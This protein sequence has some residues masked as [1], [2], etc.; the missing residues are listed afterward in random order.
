[1]S[2][3]CAVGATPHVAQFATT[4]HR[5]SAVDGRTTRHSGYAVSQQ[6]RKLVEQGFGWM[7]A[8][9]GLRKLRHRGGPLVTWIYLH[10]GRLQHRAT[11]AT[12][13]GDGMTAARQQSSTSAH[14]NPAGTDVPEA[15][16][17]EPEAAGRSLTSSAA[18]PD[19]KRP[20]ASQGKEGVE[21]QSL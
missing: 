17:L 20:L 15:R 2:M 6:K 8:I 16:S 21:S 18:C 13:A 4:P 9:G 12:P 3:T 19:E 7:K 1:V 14:P 11:P 10:R 5:R